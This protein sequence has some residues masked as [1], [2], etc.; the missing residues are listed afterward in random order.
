MRLNAHY[1]KELR[2]QLPNDPQERILRVAEYTGLYVNDIIDFTDRNWEEDKFA[3]ND[4]KEV[5]E[6]IYIDFRSDGTAYGHKRTALITFMSF[7]YLDLATALSLY[8]DKEKPDIPG[9]VWE[10]VITKADPPQVAPLG[11]KS[12][13]DA[14]KEFINMEPAFSNMSADG[15]GFTQDAITAI[16]AH[17]TELGYFSGR[18]TQG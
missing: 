11:D 6:E 4:E 17:L 5:L 13:A 3:F 16:S 9:K 14:E 18:L 2:G 12:Y 10:Y 8:A 15:I 1:S 7:S